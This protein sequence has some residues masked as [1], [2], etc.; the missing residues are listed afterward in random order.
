MSEILFVNDTFRL[1]KWYGPHPN[2]ITSSST[3]R[4]LEAIQTSSLFFILK[5]HTTSSVNLVKGHSE[6]KKTHNGD[7]EGFGVEQESAEEAQY[8]SKIFIEGLET[9]HTLHWDRDSNAGTI[10][11]QPHYCFYFNGASK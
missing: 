11:Q 4:E 3:T 8:E 7:V 10:G 2:R 9:E 1:K 5:E 6:S